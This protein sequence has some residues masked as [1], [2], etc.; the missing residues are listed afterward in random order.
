MSVIRTILTLTTYVL[1]IAYVLLPVSKGLP[2]YELL[3]A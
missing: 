3:S 2:A 1:L